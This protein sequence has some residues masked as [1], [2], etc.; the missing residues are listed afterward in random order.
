MSNKIESIIVK[1]DTRTLTWS[2]CD[3]RKIL[4]T[5]SDL[6][7]HHNFYKQWRDFDLS[8]TLGT[9]ETILRTISRLTVIRGTLGSPT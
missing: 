4:S 2:V 1:T 6:K 7:H 3:G 8:A 5:P 9:S